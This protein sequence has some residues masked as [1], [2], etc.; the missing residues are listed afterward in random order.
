MPLKDTGLFHKVFTPLSHSTDSNVPLCRNKKK[1]RKITRPICTSTGVGLD[2]SS[3]PPRFQE[4]GI[5]NMVSQNE[6]QL[7]GEGGKGTSRAWPPGRAGPAE[8]T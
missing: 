6:D 5:R 8:E 3:P 7:L 2:I 1:K 4:R